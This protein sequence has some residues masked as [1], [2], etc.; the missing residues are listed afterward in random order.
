MAKQ[1]T[2]EM[3]TNLTL[4]VSRATKSLNELSRSVKQSTNEWKVQEQQMKQAGDSIGASEAKYK[5][6]NAVVDTQKSKVEALK[7]ALATNNT[8]TAKGQKQQ[9]FLT[10]ELAKAERQLNS[11][12]GQL[13]KATQSYKYQS[14]GIAKLNEEIK[15]SNDLTTA[16]VSRL[17]A[18][19][20]TTEANKVR[21]QGLSEAL[22]KY[23][24]VLKI[25][26]SELLKI[27]EST[28]KSSDEYRKQQ[29]RI[30]QTGAKIANLSSDIKHLNGEEIKPNLSGLN[31][32]KTKLE[33]L[34]EVTKKTNHA[35]RNIFLGN[36]VANGVSNAL[37]NMYSQFSQLIENAKEYNKEQQVMN[38]TWNT[39]TGSASKGKSMVDS[40][41]NISTAFGQTSE[42]TNELEQQFYHV[43]NQ[44]DP[45]DQLTKSM[46]TM[47]D[48][49][50]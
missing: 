46:L 1:I 4:D 17:E 7:H 26:Q 35:F 6:L 21:Q 43:F 32:A 15:H 44:K 50:G 36:L 47:A 9:E 5:G 38:A 40:V 49:I 19:G 22:G 39:L 27:A 12:Q 2:A 11:Y 13:N 45:T 3:A 10:A 33:Q 29:L 16:R 18:E 48:T 23:N 41:N 25:Q 28:G 30:E 8:E 24:S 31:L 20:K 34:N 37:S 42:V 14:S